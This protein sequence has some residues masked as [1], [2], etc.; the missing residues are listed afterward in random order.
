MAT[1]EMIDLA[2]EVSKK[3]Y[4]PYSHFPIG[5]VLLTKDGKIFTGVNVENASFG[6]TNCGERTAIFKAVSEGYQSF[7]ELVVYG[8]TEEPVSPCG[9]CRQVMTEFMAPDA[10]ITLVAKD[11]ST[12][13]MTLEELLPYSFR[14]LD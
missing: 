9:A 3:A 5:A 8:E 7:S 4:V 6:L 2:I 10:L 12:K 11:K 14:D 1:T 13:V